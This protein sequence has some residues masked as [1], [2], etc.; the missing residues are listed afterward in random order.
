MLDTVCSLCVH[1]YVMDEVGPC[2]CAR[3]QAPLPVVCPETLAHLHETQGRRQAPAVPAAARRFRAILR[4]RSEAPWIPPVAMETLS[5]V[6]VSAVDQAARGHRDAGYG[7]LV[8][9]LRAAEASGAAG[10]PWGAAL[11]RCCREVLDL[12]ASRYDVST[13]AEGPGGE[14]PFLT[15][16]RLLAEPPL[17]FM[18]LEE[19]AAVAGWTS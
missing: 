15:G 7:S 9:G 19:E 16:P 4:T 10:A 3:C 18:D 8:E 17:A 12:Y 1:L 2:R 6:L 5:A 14:P 13:A 11:T